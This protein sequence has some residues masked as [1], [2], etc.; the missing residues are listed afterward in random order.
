MGIKD[1]VPDFGKKNVP[2]HH[3]DESPF[4]KLQHEMNRLFGNFFKDFG[5]NRFEERFEDRMTF[6]PHVDVRETDKNIIVTADLPG[7]EVQ[8]ID[9][10]VASDSLIV[11]GE[12]REESREEKRNYFL[13]ERSYG[14]FHR[15]IPLPGRVDPGAVDAKFKNGVLHVQLRKE[16][17]E[18]EKP[19][20]IEVKIS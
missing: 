2:V 6:T 4:L 13:L 9:I 14:A 16:R 11:K 8:D 1:L 17:S 20:K 19:K 18:A 10:S 12:K 15:V 3:T 7:L 5:L